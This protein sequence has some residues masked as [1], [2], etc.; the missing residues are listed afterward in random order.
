MVLPMP[1]IRV[2][3]IAGLRI[4]VVPRGLV[5]VFVVDALP[6]L[7]PQNAQRI[8]VLYPKTASPDMANA[9]NSLE[10]AIFWLTVY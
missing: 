9:Y 10:G 5:A 4:S 1:L 3:L 6:L 7:I 8:A 2:R